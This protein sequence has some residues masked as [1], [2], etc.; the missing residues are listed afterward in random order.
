MAQYT[1]IQNQLRQILADNNFL[2]ES[3][4]YGG[5]THA[6]MLASEGKRLKDIILRN[7]NQH[8]ATFIPTQY[9]RTHYWRKSLGIDVSTSSKN[10]V[11]IYFDDN[12]AW[13]DATI[14]A[15]PVYK[16]IVMDTGWKDRSYQTPH[17]LGFQGLHYIEKSIQEW[18]STS[19]YGLRI[20]IKV[21]IGA[22]QM[23]YDDFFR[24]ERGGKAVAASYT[25]EAYM[26]IIRASALGLLTDY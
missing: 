26:P 25:N 7:I 18:A 19:E 3:I 12:L 20:D 15:F 14:K 13:G 9:H 16:P 21:K 8:Y 22:G 5:K 11:T 24:Y 2:A 23:A 4:D 10:V 6:E 1:S 17:F